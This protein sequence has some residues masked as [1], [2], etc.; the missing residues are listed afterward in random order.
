MATEAATKP[1]LESIEKALAYRENDLKSRT[2][3]GSITFETASD[4][5]NRIFSILSHL[6]LLPLEHLTDQAIAQIN[7]QL[8]E[9]ISHLDQIDQFNIEQANP[10]QVRDSLVTGIHNQADQF[11]TIATPWIPFLAYQKGDVAENIEALTT[12]VK[13]AEE[14]IKQAK[15]EIGEKKGEID[16]IITAAREAS[17]GA[18]AAVFTKDFKTEAETLHTQAKSWLRVT[19]IF[20]FGTVCLALLMYF[21]VE[22]VSDTSV[23][24]QKFGSKVAVLG[25]LIAATVWCGRNYKALMHQ[26]TINKH[27]ALSLQTFQA[28]SHAASDDQAKDAVLMETTRAIF[29]KNPTGYIDQKSESQENQ[30]RIVEVARLAPVVKNIDD[31]VQ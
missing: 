23:V 2:M 13:N 30:T 31:A 22:P 1:L 8:T 26:A 3:W 25:I 20:A 16:G 7:K 14:L 19:A 6:N 24:I 29:G 28:F 11:Y 4:D 12:S 9:V 5:L 17:A 21:L 15:K 27:R 10:T 18:G